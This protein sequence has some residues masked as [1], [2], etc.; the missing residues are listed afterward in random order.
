MQGHV[1]PSTDPHAELQAVETI[2]PAD[3][4][5]IDRPAF[6]SQQDPDPLRAEPGASMRQIANA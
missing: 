5:A 2:E 1:F 4:L 3:T 6:P